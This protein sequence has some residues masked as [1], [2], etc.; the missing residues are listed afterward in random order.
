MQSNVEIKT[1]AITMY[2]WENWTSSFLLPVFG[3]FGT[4]TV[5]DLLKL[6][7]HQQC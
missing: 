4:Y 6:Y 7:L 2:V 3:D 1:F 5:A